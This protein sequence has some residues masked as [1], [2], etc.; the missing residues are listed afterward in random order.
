MAVAGIDG[1]GTFGPGTASASVDWFGSVRTRVGIAKDR[2]LFFLTAG[3]AVSGVTVSTGTA[4]AT[5]TVFGL[6]AGGG[7]EYAVTDFSP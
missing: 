4:S 1:T 2:V 5:D 3:L 7:V 6:T